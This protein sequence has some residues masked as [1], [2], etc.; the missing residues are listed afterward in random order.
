MIKKTFW[1]FLVSLFI[2]LTFFPLFA[3][4]TTW[5]SS[6]NNASTITKFGGNVSFGINLADDAGLDFAY[7]SMNGSGDWRNYTLVDL[8]DALS[9]TL[10]ETN[11]TWNTRS[12]NVCARFWF[13]DT[14]SNANESSE[15][16]FLVANTEPT[17]P[18]S[19]TPTSGNQTT[20]SISLEC[21]ALGDT[22]NDTIYYEIYGDTNAVP[23]TLKQ[24]TTANTYA[25]TL[26]QSG[27]YYYRCV[28][29]DAYDNSTSGT[30]I[31]YKYV[32]LQAPQTNISIYNNAS[33]ITRVNG[34]VNWTANISD[35]MSLSYAWLEHNGTNRDNGA[36]KLFNESIISISGTNYNVSKQIII[37]VTR[38]NYTCARFWF[39]DTMNYVN[40]TD[41]SCFTLMNT[42]PSIN[43]QTNVPSAPIENDV[44]Y[45]YANVTDDDKDIIGW[46]NFTITAYNGT[47]VMDRQNASSNSGDLWNSSNFASD[48]IGTWIWNITAYDG[49]SMGNAS[50][51]FTISSWNIIY[52]NVTG[53]LALQDSTGF[54]LIK[55]Y[56]T[57]TSESNV[58]AADS[59]STVSFDSLK[60]L[61]RNT[62]GDYVSSDFDD[63]D[64]LLNMTGVADSINRTFVSNTNPKKTATFT[65]FGNT[66]SNVPVINSTNSSSF[67]T[68]M[69]WDSSD[70]IDNDKQFDKLDAEDIVFVTAVNQ[71]TYGKYGLYDYEISVPS[72]LRKYKAANLFQVSLYAEIK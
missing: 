14:D 52:G 10:N 27:V 54:T 8:G 7:L 69:L 39:N 45:I 19:I 46:V 59:D 12:Q 64:S 26:T 48:A 60:A 2:F 30:A 72:Y 28:A 15:T 36:P 49:V 21:A 11:I 70:D 43:L 16:C 41:W 32:D 1:L 53:Q 17:T 68:G 4:S 25:W 42:P 23:S 13:N 67:I 58:Y 61:S 3:S 66:L 40:N 6:T 38:A 9:I 37:N 56:V 62:D 63:I 18:A 33:T 71:S 35:D 57:N 55:W 50:G 31:N 47:K 24:N 65:I 22:D 34:V 51:S 29:H 44:V 5:N 20:D